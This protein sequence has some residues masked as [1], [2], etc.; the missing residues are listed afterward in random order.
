MHLLNHAL[1]YRCSNYIRNYFRT[2]VIKI[3]RLFLKPNKKI[4]KPTQKSYN[5]TNKKNIF[6]YDQI[7]SEKVFKNTASATYYYRFLSLLFETDD[8]SANN[9]VNTLFLLL[10]ECVYVASTT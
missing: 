7:G 1:T 10:F 6:N 5:Y 2:F 8:K 3:Q 9:S 4:T